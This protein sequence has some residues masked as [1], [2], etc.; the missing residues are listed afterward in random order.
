MWC[1]GVGVPDGPV[2]G[3]VSQ[4][5]V[6][7]SCPAGIKQQISDTA[8]VLWQDKGISVGQLLV[9][10]P[11]A[12]ATA[13]NARVLTRIMFVLMGTCVMM[14]PNQMGQVRE[15]AGAAIYLY[16]SSSHI[17][18]YR[19]SK[20]RQLRRSTVDA[21][22]TG[23]RHW[24]ASSSNTVGVSMKRDRQ[25]MGARRDKAPSHK[26]FCLP[27]VAPGPRLRSFLGDLCDARAPVDPVGRSR[28][29]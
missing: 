4:N 1:C 6:C 14:A 20:V 24:L 26:L 9:P 8:V 22:P 27:L 25:P 16:K 18:E 11:A 23:R 19:L 17:S 7:R 3:S 10:F 15:N 21:T 5:C 12:A 29:P 28:A 13:A 2:G